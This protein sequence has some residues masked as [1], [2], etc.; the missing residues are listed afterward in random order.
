MCPSLLDSFIFVA[1][2]FGKQRYFHI[3]LLFLGV[4]FLTFNVEGSFFLHYDFAKIIPSA[5]SSSFSS[6]PYFF[7][8]LGWP[9]VEGIFLKS[10]TS[11]SMNSRLFSSSIRSGEG[12]L[13]SIAMPFGEERI[14]SH[15]FL[16][17]IVLPNDKNKL[18]LKQ[19]FATFSQKEINS[20]CKPN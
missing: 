2:F 7:C 19:K 3:F 14:S 16:C 8:S 10:S 9:D 11:S 20:L 13:T 15:F 12:Q 18:P 4:F 1:L 5:S 17:M 6:Q